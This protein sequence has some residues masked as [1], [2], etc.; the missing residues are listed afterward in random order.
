MTS[1]QLDSSLGLHGDRAFSTSI[2]LHS[3]KD[4]DA[5]KTYSFSTLKVDKPAKGVIQVELNRPDRLNALN[6]DSW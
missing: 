6:N 5:T 3:R 2:R 1:G 4:P